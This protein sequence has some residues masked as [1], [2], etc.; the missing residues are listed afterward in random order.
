MKLP[1]S[2]RNWISIIGASI[3][4]L[5]FVFIIFLLLITFIFDVGSSYVGL[6][7]YII[8][9]FFLITGLL[10]IPIGMY[11]CK[12]K[13]KK[14]EKTVKLTDWPIID[15]NNIGT[16]NATIIFS[17]GTI[18]LLIFSAVGSYEAFHYTESVEFC[19]KLCHTVMEPEYV[20]YYESSH[21]RVSCVECHVGNGADWYVKIGRAHV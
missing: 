21:E 8:L 4:L 7:I 18:V 11:A 20:A 9:P 19:G 16:R 3:A 6:F 14:R 15:F 12:R 1:Q 10:L 17:V 13:I 2:L 5:N